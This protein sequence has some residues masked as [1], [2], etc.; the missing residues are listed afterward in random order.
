MPGGIS[1]R[2]AAYQHRR[3]IARRSVTAFISKE[4]S[5]SESRWLARHRSGNGT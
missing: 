3:K 1:S 4:S 2:L 5:S